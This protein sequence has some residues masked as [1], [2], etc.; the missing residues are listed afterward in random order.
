MLDAYITSLTAS[1]HLGLHHVLPL[2]LAI[3]LAVSDHANASI[4]YAPATV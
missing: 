4:T 2:S 3:A 1:N